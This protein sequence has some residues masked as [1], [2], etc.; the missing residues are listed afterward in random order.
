MSYP[1]YRFKSIASGDLYI[2]DL[3]ATRTIYIK[4]TTGVPSIHEAAV[5]GGEE[6]ASTLYSTIVDEITDYLRV[7]SHPPHSP[8]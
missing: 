2:Q 1:Q 3:S 4:L 5:T 8:H 7:G 6:I